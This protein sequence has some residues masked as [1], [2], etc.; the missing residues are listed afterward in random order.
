MVLNKKNKEQQAEVVRALIEPVVVYAGMELIDVEYRREPSGVILRLTIDKAGGVTIDDCSDIS[1]L[2]GDLLDAKD[3]LPGSYNLEVTSPGINR[4]LKK[5]DD[6]E[7]FAGQKV[8]IK[9]RKLID[10][11]RNFKGILHG[12]REDF[13]VVFSEKT[14][15]NIPFDLV[16]KAR[17]DI[18]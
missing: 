2:V 15:L 10:G 3:S 8:L 11:R 14:I 17:L 4:P 12:T 7:R 9:T 1:R 16:A 18:I 13:I 5:K 6:F